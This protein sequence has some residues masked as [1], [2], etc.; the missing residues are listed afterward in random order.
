MSSTAQ[1]T[2]IT[3]YISGWVYYC[4]SGDLSMLYFFRYYNDV[5]STLNVGLFLTNP[6]STMLIC[7]MDRWSSNIIC[8]KNRGDKLSKLD[9]ILVAHLNKLRVGEPL[10]YKSIYFIKSLY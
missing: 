2:I 10:T 5:F 6:A 4:V 9:E 8:V 7:Q 1:Y 3:M